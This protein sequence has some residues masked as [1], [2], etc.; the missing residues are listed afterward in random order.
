MNRERL[1][2]LWSRVLAGR[3]LTPDE[4]AELAA[5][6]EADPAL[7]S[8][9]LRD[10]QLDGLLRALPSNR[11]E[12]ERAL[13]EFSD[14]LEAERDA[15]RF[16]RRVEEH[17]EDS[18]PPAPSVKRARGARLRI[19]AGRRGT[20]TASWGVGLAAAAVLVAAWLIST[21]F[22]SSPPPGPSSRG[23]P[24]AAIPG[25]AVPQIK[26]LAEEKAGKEREERKGIARNLP[27]AEERKRRTAEEEVQPA[28]DAERQAELKARE[29]DLARVAE[30]FQEKLRAAQDR[31]RQAAEAAAEAKEPGAFSPT[32]PATRA[33]VG[34]VERG[35]GAFLTAGEART[36]ARGGE[37]LAAGQGLEVGP[38]GSAVILYPDKTLLEVGPETEAREFQAE[39]GKRFYIVRGTVRA[40][41]SPQPKDQPMVIATPHGEATILGTTFRITVDPDPQKGTTLKVTQGMV[42][43][44]SSLAGRTVDVPGGHYAVAAAGVALAARPL[45]IDQIVLLPRQA[46]LAGGEWALVR[47]AGAL[48]GL[49][50]EAARTNYRIRSTPKG[51]EYE[52][53]RGRP[54][55]VFTFAAQADKEYFVW[56]RGR[57]LAPDPRHLKNNEFALEIPN[58]RFSRKCPYLGKTGEGAFVYSIPPQEGPGWTWI[59]G[60][61][62]LKG[63]VPP[64]SVMFARTGPQELRLYAVETPIRIDVIWLSATQKARPPADQGP[65]P[66]EDR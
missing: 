62:E 46:L 63:D 66:A 7:R 41:V 45:P 54:A 65:P 49:T 1:E 57:S 61:A 26:G 27:S 15:S 32:T 52:P 40:Q 20:S 8:E 33:A 58:A 19:P 56:V 47:D 3:R 48:S 34:K 29:T 42:R 17:L 31:E 35:Q 10:Y 24:D 5:A 38:G 39:G 37:D 43:F 14:R 36:E 22:S 30:A 21:V 59:G 44:R 55:A 11:E 28:R 6:L 16:I 13:H 4:E 60:Y 2:D 50:L 25:E 12:E 53:L 18:T 9:F 64:L 51:F 23:G